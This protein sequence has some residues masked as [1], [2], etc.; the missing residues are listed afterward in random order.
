[1]L[2]V[3]FH[4][5]AEI[6]KLEGVECFRHVPL[7]RIFWIDLQFPSD[8]E[9][10]K[11]ESL[12]K[13]DFETLKSENEV[14]SNYRF[15]EGE[16]VVLITSNFITKKDNHFEN[17]PVFFYLLS[18]TLITERNA[19]L[20][21]FAETV[22]KI[23]RNRKAFNNGSEVLEGILETKVDIDADYIEQIAKD[24]AA[25]GRSLSVK[26]PDKEDVLLKISEYQ[27][28]ATLSRDSFIDKQRVVSGLLKS[29]IIEN[30]ERMKILI[31]DINNMLEYSSYMF[32]RLEY[33]QNTVLGLINLE[34]N[35]AIKIFTIV[36]VVFMPPTLIASI[37]GMNFKV[38]P[39]L[40]WVA[41]YPLA[42]LLIISSSLLT[43][44]IFKRKKWL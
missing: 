4:E 19:D 35:K 37:Y 43:L 3:F 36:A 21:S 26:N 29:N 28:A 2:R 33:L 13:I 25:L 42:L 31:K 22:K 34:Q 11:V 9:K 14:E 44:F 5:D 15:F 30:K 8:G 1:M 12:F 17:T 32:M 27:E 41:G 40:E 39:E 20:A 38:M 24:I 10:K 6:S 7:E 23:K 18:N 16:D